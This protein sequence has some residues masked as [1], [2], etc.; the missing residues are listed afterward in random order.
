MVAAVL[1]VVAVIISVPRSAVVFYRNGVVL[2]VS[3]A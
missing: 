3:V 2:V 1:F